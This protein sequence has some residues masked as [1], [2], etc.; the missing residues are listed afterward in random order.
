[1]MFDMYLCIFSA[2]HGVD[3]LLEV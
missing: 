1:M 3:Y 2:F